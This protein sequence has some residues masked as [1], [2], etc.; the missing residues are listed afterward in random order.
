MSGLKINKKSIVYLSLFV[1]FYLILVI[2]LPDVSHPGDMGHWER[3]SAFMLEEG[4]VNIYDYGIIIFNFVYD[5]RQ[6]LEVN[7][8]VIFCS[9]GGFSPQVSLSVVFP[10]NFLASFRYCF[11]M[12][13]P[14]QNL[15]NI[16]D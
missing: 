7:G 11:V 2:F 16:A 10:S 9:I 14:F 15:P 12:G 4:F 5:V 3:W 6:P 13:R 1:I 8:F